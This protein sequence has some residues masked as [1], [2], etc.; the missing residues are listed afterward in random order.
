MT[1]RAKVQSNAAIELL[2]AKCSCEKEEKKQHE[3]VDG[4]MDS[5]NVGY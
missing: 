5:R 1:I 2:A 3:G 4:V